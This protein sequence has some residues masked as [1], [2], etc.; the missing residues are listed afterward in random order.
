M[1]RAADR[2]LWTALS[3]ELPDGSVIVGDCGEPR[4]VSGDCTWEFSFDG[5]SRPQL[6]PRSAAVVQ[7]LTPPTSVAALRSGFEP[8]LHVSATSRS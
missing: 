4:L 1:V 5:W 3:D 8:V 7:V 6:R 2:L